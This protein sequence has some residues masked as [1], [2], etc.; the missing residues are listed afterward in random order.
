MNPETLLILDN[1]LRY[2]LLTFLSLFLFFV[3]FAS[4]RSRARKWRLTERFRQR[5]QHRY[6]GA[7]DEPE[8]FALQ[9]N[10]LRTWFRCGMLAA[11]LAGFSFLV[12]S[13][14]PLP[15]LANFATN[16]SWQI[17]PLRLTALQLDRFHEG[18]SLDGE[19]WN[20]TGES[21]Q[22]LQAV[23]TI[24]DHNREQLDSVVVKVTPSPLGAKSGGKFS[25]TYN[26]NSP[27]IYGYKVDF[28]HAEG[29]E[30]LHQKGF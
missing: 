20:Q 9:I 27:L 22:D 15:F 18:F 28:L 24:W 17:A 2:A 8:F 11:G 1:S 10:Y 21:I 14:V 5:W 29:D 19:I 3:G 25:L 13:L 7:G 16:P 4:W 6:Q 26:R 23:I 12:Y 30:I